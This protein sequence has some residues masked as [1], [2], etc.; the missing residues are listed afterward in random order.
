MHVMT[1][2][3]T[4]ISPCE[5]GKI[6]IFVASQDKCDQVFRDLLRSGRALHTHMPPLLHPNAPP[7]THMTPL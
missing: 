1:W 5:Q 3:A 4:S 6:L 2:R 7:D